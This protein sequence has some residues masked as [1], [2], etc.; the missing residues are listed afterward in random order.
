[1]TVISKF[2]VHVGIVAA[3]TLFAAGAP[4][5]AADPAADG[6]KAFKKYCAAC[7]TVEEGK[8]RVGPSLHGVVGRTA[9]S[10][11]GFAYSAANKGS[12]IT[13]T[14]EKLEPYLTNPQA[15]VPGTKM[16]FAGIKDAGER[17]AVIAYLKTK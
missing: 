10:V 14:E 1:M 13:W 11:A 16:T 4:A 17:S 5:R 12:G 2:Y 6:E 9:G 7:H 3:L 8:N 15:V